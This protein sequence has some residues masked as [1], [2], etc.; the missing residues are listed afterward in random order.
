MALTATVTSL[1]E[2]RARVDVVVEPAE[3][4]RAVDAAARS[5]A[6]GMKM[7]G[8]RKGKVPAPVVISRVGREAVLDEAVR[9]RLAKWYVAAIGEAA[10]SPVGDPDISLGELPGAGE[11]F[12]FAIEIG[13]RPV[14]KLGEWRGLEVARREAEADEDAVTAQLEELR[15]RLARL[16]TVERAAASGDFVVMDYAGEIDGEPIDGGSARDQ[17]VELGSGRLIPGFEEGLTG[18][19]AGDERTLN[20]SFP[21]DYGAE[22]LAGREAVFAVTVKEVKEKRLPELDDDFAG[23]TAGFDTLEELREDIRSRMRESD[24]ARAEAEYR[25]AAL[26]AAVAAATIDVP[27]ALVEARAQEAFER[28]LHSLSH[29]G[30]SKDAYLRLTQKTEQEVLEEA[31]PD[32]AQSLKREAVLAALIEAEGIDPTDEQIAEALEESVEPDESGKRPDPA[33]MVETLRKNGRLGD[34]REDVA[35]RMALDALIAA[36]TPIDPGRAAAREKLWTPGS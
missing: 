1:P 2:S 25:E 7:P 4:E 21:A 19:S 23:D 10:I 18:A 5:M 32:A 9:E 36:A 27:D 14:A 31:K 26:D 29:R 17:L 35:S 30:I 8:F 12:T 13:V 3:V 11:P 20:L 33:E 22:H 28:L 16:E 6:A 15:D 24:E 34:V